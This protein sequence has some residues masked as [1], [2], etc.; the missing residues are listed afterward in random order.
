MRKKGRKKTV[1]IVFVVACGLF[2]L[3][4]LD[5]SLTVRQYICQTVKISVPIRIVFLSDLHSCDY[6][7][8]QQE[9]LEK[10]EAQQPDVVLLGG[11]WVDD[12]F[13]RLSPE[14]GFQAAERLAEKF[15]AFYV[16][17]NHEARSGKTREIKAELT[18]RG[19][20]V[21]SGKTVD[22]KIRGQRFQLC[23]IDDPAEA[24]AAWKDQLERLRKSADPHALSILLTHRPER[25][26]AF[27]GFDLVFA[28]HAHGG[29]WRIPGLVNGLLAPNQGFFPKYAGGV[30]PLDETTLIVGRGL[31]RE[32]T[33]LPRL[34]N[35]P[36]IVVVDI[37]PEDG[38][39]SE[40]G[41]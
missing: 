37:L 32:S 33:R 10:A 6:G 2:C 41:L 1:C 18:A 11:D 26:W 40:T 14:R 8:E 25:T 20:T 4:G 24:G 39:I 21:L 15:P 22:L 7:E 29:Q 9:L 3:L 28:G 13:D 19:V 31:A 17:G 30:Y 35:P 34:Y 27:S 12:D 16:S 36:E 5:D 23:G 38:K